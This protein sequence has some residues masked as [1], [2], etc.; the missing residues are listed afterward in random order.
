MPPK[1]LS[2]RLTDLRLYIDDFKSTLTTEG[3]TDEKEGSAHTL[4]ETPQRPF[5]GTL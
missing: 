5:A 3:K 4:S 1:Q 2:K